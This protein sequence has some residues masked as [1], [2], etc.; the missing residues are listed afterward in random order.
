MAAEPKTSVN[1]I[2]NSQHPMWIG[3]GPEVTFLYNDA[4]IHVI[5]L[6]K[7]QWALGRPAS[8]VWVEI[9][10]ICGPLVDKVFKKGEATFCERRALLYEPG[11]FPRG[12]LL[13]FF[14]QPH[15]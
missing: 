12:N 2:L 11:G 15:P 9:W 1:L 10:N 5:G 6:V 14:L 4:Y 3:W 8:E 7:H 13:F